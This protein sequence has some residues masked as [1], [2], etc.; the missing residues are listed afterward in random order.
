MPWRVEGLWGKR[1]G[2]HDW[3][4]GGGVGLGRGL[5]FNRLC[6]RDLLAWDHSWFGKSNTQM[7]STTVHFLHDIDLSRAQNHRMVWA[8]RD[9]KDHL[10]PSPCHGQQ[11]LPLDQVAQSPI[12][13]GLEHRQAWGMH[14]FSGQPVLVPHHAHSKELNP[15]MPFQVGSHQ[16]G[17]AREN[18]LPRPAAHASLDAA[19]DVAGFLCCRHTFLS[20]V[21]LLIHQHPQV[22]LL[23][24]AFSTFSTQPVFV[25]GMPQ[26][27]CSIL[28]LALLNFRTLAQT[29]LSHLWRSLPSC[30]SVTPHSLVSPTNLWRA[31]S[32]VRPAYV[33]HRFVPQVLLGSCYPLHGTAVPAKTMPWGG[34]ENE[35]VN[36]S[37]ESFIDLYVYWIV[38]LSLF[39]QIFSFRPFFC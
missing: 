31:G 21:E 9:L 8:K 6:R 3:P 11:C 15:D 20:H 25:L 29:H 10:A 24:A 16:S 2:Q 13:F 34:E 27:R 33:I 23:R 28:H 37:L 36:N 4:S 7:P 18:H 30:L 12:Q 39:C 35:H 38:S 19:Q 17:S 14:N 26:P 1:K 5:A 32:R 22:L